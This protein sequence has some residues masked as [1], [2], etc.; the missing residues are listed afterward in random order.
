MAQWYP[1]LLKLGGRRCVVFGGGRVAERKAEGLLQAGAEVHVVS[2]SATPTIREWADAGRLIWHSREADERDAA[3]AALAFAATDKP[4][5]N[6][7]LAEAAARSG[8]PANVA[9]DGESGDFLVPATLRRGGLVIA[10]SASGA[11]PALAKR[12]VGELAERYG[13]DYNENVEALRAIRAC[14]KAAVADPEDRRALLAAA[15]SDEA[16]AEWR[17]SEEWL[18]DRE[19]LV[20][21]LRQLAS[22]R[23]P[24]G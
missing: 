14:V 10:A 2:P 21:R 5:V 12:I 11:G 4:D 18:H 23:D 24:K 19:K 7:R 15:V 13:Q 16:L 22:E 20:A 9:D 6:R 1:I 3:G 17:R 8:V